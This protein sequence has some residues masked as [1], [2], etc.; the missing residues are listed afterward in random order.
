MGV[1][2]Q[3]SA[4]DFLGWC[5][6]TRGERSRAAHGFSI[7]RWAEGAFKPTKG[8]GQSHQ[9]VVAGWQAPD[10]KPVYGHHD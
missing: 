1:E 9:P 5:L 6:L 3:D 8:E 4:R 7:L 10:C 2:Y